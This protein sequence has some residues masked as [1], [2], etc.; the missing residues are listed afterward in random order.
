MTTCVG[1][2]VQIGSPTTRREGIPDILSIMNPKETVKTGY[3]ALSLLYRQDDA[4]S[5]Q[6]E[7]WIAQLLDAVK[8][9]LPAQF[10]DIGCGCGIPVSRDLTAAGHTVTG[11]DISQTQIER[12][13]TLVPGGRFFCLDITSDVEVSAS[14]AFIE[15][16]RFDAVVALY[17]LFHMPLDEQAALMRRM[18][19]W[20]REGGHCLMTV[21]IRPWEG[22][23][24][25]WLGS[26]ESVKMWWQQTGIDQY[27]T[28]VKEAGFEIVED[29]HIVDPYGADESP[30]FRLLHLVKRSQQPLATLAID[31]LIT[32]IQ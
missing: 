10:L 1:L 8:P 20:L 15:Q 18:A 31:S 16:G 7:P 28:W 5:G 2:E 14:E 26:D 22:V 25:G 9:T 24:A 11:I 3:D 27:R 19:G 12:A 30:G 29:E 13:K 23:L 17:V 6:Y 4:P 32:D 21:G